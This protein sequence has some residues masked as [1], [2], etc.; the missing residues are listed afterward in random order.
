MARLGVFKLQN[1]KLHNYQLSLL[2]LSTDDFQLISLSQPEKRENPIV[3]R[4]ARE[5]WPQA[6]GVGITRNLPSSLRI[7]D[8]NRLA[9]LAVIPER[10]REPIAGKVKPTRDGTRQRRSHLNGLHNFAARC[11]HI[12]QRRRRVSHDVEVAV[13]SGFLI[14]EIESRRRLLSIL[15]RIPLGVLLSCVLMRAAT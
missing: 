15:L 10:N 11:D 1:Y 13:A 6:G 3:R 9:L 5:R 7:R 2:C 14:C 4:I 8:H 12:D